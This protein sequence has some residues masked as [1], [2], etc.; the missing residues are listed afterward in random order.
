MELI[1]PSRWVFANHFE[2]CLTRL[3][4]HHSTD[5]YGEI[6]IPEDC[7]VSIHAALLLISLINQLSHCGRRVALCFDST[8]GAYSYL[9]RMGFFECLANAIEVRPEGIVNFLGGLQRCCL[10]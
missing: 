4:P 7:K 9:S 2:Q 6:R 10:V 8:E 3:K 1:F 5:P